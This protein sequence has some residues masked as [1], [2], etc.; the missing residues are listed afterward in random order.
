[1][2]LAHL[3]S[4]SRGAVMPKTSGAQRAS[5]P[6]TPGWFWARILRK[7]F[8]PAALLGSGTSMSEYVCPVRINGLSA[9]AV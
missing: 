4:G 2:S 8:P 3:R 1:M 9:A 5:V 6:V 7:G